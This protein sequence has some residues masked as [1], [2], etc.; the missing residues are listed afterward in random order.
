LLKLTFICGPIT[1]TIQKIVHFI[2][3]LISPQQTQEHQHSHIEELRST[4]QL[5]HQEGS[6]IK[7]DK[8]ML[9]S[10]LDLNLME[11]DEIMTHRKNIKS[12]DFSLEPKKI[13]NQA[14]AIKHSRIPLWLKQ[15]ENIVAVLNTKKLLRYLQS[16]NDDIKNLD[17]KKFTEKPWFVPQSNNLKNQLLQFRKKKKKFAVVIDEYGTI[18]GLLTIEDI[19]E[20]IVGKV[21]EEDN[22]SEE[23]IVKILSNN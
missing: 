9:E 14:L 13:I 16:N 21:H 18:L 20:E 19:I 10:I 4:V 7:D 8:D 11:L 6:I 5:K 17:L 12:I 2:I 23:K 15:K 22:Q 3:K 1:G